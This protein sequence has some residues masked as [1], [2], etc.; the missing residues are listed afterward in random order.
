MCVCDIKERNP[1]TT[2]LR[3]EESVC[4]AVNVVWDGD[5]LFQSR[6]C[7]QMPHTLAKRL[8]SAGLSRWSIDRWKDRIMDR[9]E[10]EGI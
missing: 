7:S 1:W 5:L 4:P 10:Q 6:T 3:R 8:G 2:P 9:E